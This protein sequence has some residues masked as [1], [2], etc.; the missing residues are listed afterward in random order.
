MMDTLAHDV[1]WLVVA[2]VVTSYAAYRILRMRDN[3]R[4]D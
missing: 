1:C 3:N 2:I 4:S